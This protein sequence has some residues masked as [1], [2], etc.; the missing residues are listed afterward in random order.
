MA[1]KRCS[2]RRRRFTKLHI[3]RVLTTFFCLFITV[4]AIAPPCEGLDHFG[5]LQT[6]ALMS[7]LFFFDDLVET[8]LMQASDKSKRARRRLLPFYSETVC[9]SG[10]T[11]NRV[12]AAEEPNFFC[13]HSVGAQ[14]TP[15]LLR[16]ELRESLP[17]VPNVAP[18]G[19][20]KSLLRC[21]QPDK[22]LFA[23]KTP[24]NR[25]FYF[26]LKDHKVV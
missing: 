18:N 6:A 25:D 26:P 23:W 14:R 3:L 11:G 21:P 24:C 15:E 10:G 9:H 1:V 7:T 17:N 22:F 4:A 2:N 16:F 20:L 12:E 19:G 8:L 5:S 13:C